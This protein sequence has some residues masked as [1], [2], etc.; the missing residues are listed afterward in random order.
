MRLY[1][2]PRTVAA[3]GSSVHGLLQARI[4]EWVA[5][6]FSRDFPDPGIKPRSPAVQPDALASEPPGKCVKAVNYTEKFV[7]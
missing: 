5:V 6:P 1:G 4:L 2:T 3:P 7:S